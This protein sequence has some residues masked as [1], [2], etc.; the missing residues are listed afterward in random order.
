MRSPAALPAKIDLRI[1][2][3]GAFG[4]ESDV[5]SDSERHAAA[6]RG[7]VDRRDRRFA[8]LTL[9]VE[10]PDIEFVHQRPDLVWRASSKLDDIQ[11]SA[12]TLCYRARDYDRSHGIVSS[13][14]F[15][16]RDHAYCQPFTLCTCR[17]LSA[18]TAP[19]SCS[20]PD[21]PCT[22][23]RQRRWASSIASCRMP[24][25]KRGRSGSPAN[26]RQNP[27]RRC[28]RGAPPDVGLRE[29]NG[30]SQFHR[31]NHARRIIDLAGKLAAIVGK[32]SNPKIFDA[33]A[34]A[35]GNFEREA[36][37]A[38]LWRRGDFE[39][40]RERRLRLAHGGAMAGSVSATL[41][42]SSRAAFS[43]TVWAAS[44]V[45]ARRLTRTMNGVFPANIDV[46]CALWCRKFTLAILARTLRNAGL[47]R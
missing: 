29:G 19:S 3:R 30:L 38:R 14:A 2:E 33:L 9:H 10:Q 18:A 46:I 43:N 13:R 11:T 32:R 1:T 12:E 15:K 28:A 34:F 40:I 6:T 41:A 35:N 45:A 31:V 44:G 39:K 4:G 27:K 21:A 20:S 36:Q 23:N 25:R 22:P 37:R 16:R 24:N 17:A 26:W 47:F 7:A 42:V 8:E 5:A